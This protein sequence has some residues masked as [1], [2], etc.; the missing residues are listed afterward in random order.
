[1]TAETLYEDGDGDRLVA[2]IGEDAGLS[3]GVT[4]DS[5]E[6]YVPERVVAAIRAA[7][8]DDRITVQMTRED[9][10]ELALILT[11][12]RYHMDKGDGHAVPQPRW[13]ANC[14]VS[15]AVDRALGLLPQ[16]S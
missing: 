2:Y 8:A 15:Q 13:G 14:R 1:M 6:V 11:G 4:S 10:Q 9:A 7:L 5:G 12:D 3:L 16:E